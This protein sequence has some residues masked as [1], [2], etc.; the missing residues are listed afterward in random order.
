MGSM[1][2]VLPT[3]VRGAC[4]CV[5]VCACVCGLTETSVVVVADCWRRMVDGGRCGVKLVVG[6][7]TFAGGTG[8]H[9]VDTSAGNAAAKLVGN[10]W[11]VD[12]SGRAGAS[13][14]GAITGG[15]GGGGGGGG[16][17][18]GTWTWDKALS[19]SDRR[20]VCCLSCC[21]TVC[22]LVVSTDASEARAPSIAVEVR[23]DDRP[24]GGAGL[25]EDCRCALGW[26]GD[27]LLP[28]ATVDGTGEV[29]GFGDATRAAPMAVPRPGTDTG[30]RGLGMECVFAATTDAARAVGVGCT[31]DG[32]G[33]DE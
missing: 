27:D 1:R 9:R 5:F 11:V 3:G 13:A 17:R 30:R 20:A 29:G 10:D 15:G 32:D 21:S 24:E 16:V 28:L 14:V 31:G 25:L 4:A 19:C 2:T 23:G 8:R 33:D 26:R 7:D 18:A 12:A 6:V 22:A